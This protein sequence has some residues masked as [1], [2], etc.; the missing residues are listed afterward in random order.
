MF[1]VIRAGALKVASAWARVLASEEQRFQESIGA[2]KETDPESAASDEPA[3]PPCDRDN[4][5]PDLADL[6]RQRQAKQHPKDFLYPVDK[7]ED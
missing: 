7:D 3:A 2:T 4:V 1:A 5:A 6:V